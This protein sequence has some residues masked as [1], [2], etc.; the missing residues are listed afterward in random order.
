VPADTPQ[1]RYD[2]WVRITHA[3][4]QA[5]LLKL[6]Y[7]VDTEAPVV[8]LALSPRARDPQTLE[9][10]ATVVVV[11]AETSPHGTTAQAREECRRVEVRVPDGRVIVLGRV[12]DGVFRGV[13]RPRQPITGP[14]D[15]TVVT[16]DR[17]LNERVARVSL[18]PAAAT[19]V[20]AR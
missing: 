19:V 11:D 1:G 6:Q 7:V 20:V 9:I 17:A 15:L 13:W 14:V 16:V 8:Q 18:D 4:G 10:T 3:H 2:I 12:R 5:E